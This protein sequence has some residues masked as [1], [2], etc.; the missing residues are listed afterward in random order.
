MMRRR[1]GWLWALLLGL[2]VLGGVFVV[3]AARVEVPPRLLATYLE[4][5]AA[6][7]P[8][9]LGDLVRWSA[10]TLNGL[11]RGVDPLPMR[12]P[13]GVGAVEA[14]AS[15]APAGRAVLAINEAQL[16]QA[17]QQAQP[18]DVITL[19]PGKYRFEGKWLAV[20]RPG[21]AQAR[22]TLRGQIA[23]SARLE[24][25][26][27]EGFHVSAPYWTFENLDIRGVCAEHSKCEHAFH[28]VGAARHFVARNNTLADFNAHFKINGAPGALPDQGLIEGNTLTNSAPRRTENPVT[29]IDLVG[30]SRWMVRA[31]LIADFVREGSPTTTYGAFAK[32]AGEGN[33]FERNIVLCEHRLRGRH[34][35]RV[36]LSL[37][38]GGSSRDACRDKRC[39]TEQDGGT[40][41]SNLIAFCSDSGIDVNRS[42]LSRVLHNTLIDT[43]GISVREP[44]SSAEVEGNLVDGALYARNGG[45]LHALDNL[46]TA[47]LRLFLGSH[48]VRDLF[49]DVAAL[50]FAWRGTPPRRTTTPAGP[51]ADLCGTPRP[52]QPAYGAFE[53][54]AACRAAAR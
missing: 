8:D 5:R 49:A 27:A 33:R 10:R 15:A 17:L 42:S 24:F 32:G 13:M 37:G 44:A 47:A 25:D 46:D 16:Q 39:I 14:A 53:N 20:E 30:A 29:P 50:D 43:A 45:T 52:A 28:V 40:I 2:A 3:F 6:G 9:A 35:S 19:V 23:G 38:G 1:T 36:G 7:H 41:E 26:L 4:Q 22:I 18:G 11:D 34:G 21:S 54:F 12:P 51:V 31:N 48:P